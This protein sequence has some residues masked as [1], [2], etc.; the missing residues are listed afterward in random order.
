MSME[1]AEAPGFRAARR[2]VFPG[3]TTPSDDQP[4]ARTGATLEPREKAWGLD[5]VS[6]PRERIAPSPDEIDFSVHVSMRYH[7]RRRAW[8]D[9]FHRAMMLVITVCASGG[10]A[11]IFGGLLLEAEYLAAAVAMAGAL[12]L[13]FSF[14]E[15]ARVEDALYRRFTAL[16]VEMAA[17]NTADDQQTHGWDAQRLLIRADADD[18]LEVLRRICH[19]L[20]A[21]ARGF[22]RDGFYSIWPWQRITAELVSLPPLQPLGPLGRY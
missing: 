10:V 1:N 6:A 14:P 3:A 12:E 11:A 2:G 8:L 16:A 22:D 15:R 7:A 5:A 20:E 21:E 18:R 4:E 9:R 17:A 19:N 13:A